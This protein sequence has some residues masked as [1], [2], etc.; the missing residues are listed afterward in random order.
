MEYDIIILLITI[1]AL[2]TIIILLIW[3]LGYIYNTKIDPANC[4][5]IK[6]NFGVKTNQDIKIL[7]TCGDNFNSNCNFNQIKSLKEAEEKCY[8]LEN[9]CSAFTYS[10]ITREMAIVN[11]NTTD[12]NSIISY[13]VYY[14]QN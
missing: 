12:S 8:Y 5:I 4:P 2:V 6:G 10:E 7:K 13:N 1:I 3:N 11:P 14:R 9:I